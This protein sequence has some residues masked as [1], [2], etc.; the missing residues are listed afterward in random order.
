MWLCRHSNRCPIGPRRVSSFAG[1]GLPQTVIWLTVS[2]SAEQ[3]LRQTA[4]PCRRRLR[5]RL[6]LLFQPLIGTPARTFTLCD[7]FISPRTTT[8]TSPL[9]AGHGLYILPPNTGRLRLESSTQRIDSSIP[10][11]HV[12]STIHGLRAF[13][14]PARSSSIVYQV[15]AQQESDRRIVNHYGQTCPRGTHSARYHLHR[16]LLRH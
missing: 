1:F 11:S 15:K 12:G 6:L 9:Q 13:A 8:E 14:E 2:F 7:K 5:L 4:R 16:L 10:N 3:R